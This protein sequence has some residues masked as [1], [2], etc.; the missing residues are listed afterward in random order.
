MAV[1][2]HLSESET[3][4]TEDSTSMLGSFEPRIRRAAPQQVRMV[5]AG[6]FYA[7]YHGHDAGYLEV[8][9]D[10]L[11]ALHPQG[12]TI[13]LAGDSSLDNKTW[14]FNQ[15]AA[16]ERWRPAGSHAPAVN[17]YERLLQPP[18]M[19]CDV[20]FWMNQ[21]LC[22]MRSPAFTINTAIEA[23]TLASRVGGV[24]FCCFPSVCCGLFE[25]EQLIRDRIRP[26][27]MLVISVG[28]NDV[29]LAPSIFTVLAMVLLMLTPWPFLFWFHPA[30]AYFIGMYKYQ[31]QCY[32]ER[33]THRTRPS[34][35]GVCMIYNP[36]ERNGTSWAN[37]ALCMLCYTCFPGMLQR[38]LR[39]VF[40]LA[41]CTI[42]VPGSEV[43]PIH[44][45]DALDGLCTEDYHQRVEPSVIGGQKMARLILHRLGWRCADQLSSA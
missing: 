15:G 39:L 35:I 25:Q 17:G 6:P 40:E 7:T 5:P 41:H 26:C 3:E 13:Y 32:I 1:V 14:L 36:D 27:D 20:T 45:A 4:T 22:D 21:L 43:V 16:A 42:Q 18:R 8:L 2:G 28:G 10:G 29:A 31:V 33:L 44:L 11:L 24:Q 37:M 19:V 23:T 30:V 34:K 9:L 12:A 38:R